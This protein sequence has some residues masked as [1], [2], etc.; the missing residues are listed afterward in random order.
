MF[1]PSYQPRIFALPPGCD[2]S[3]C[4]LQG[5]RGRLRDKP[6]EAMAGVELFV[7][8]HRAARRMKS[9][10]LAGNPGFLPRIRVI[11]DLARDPLI[12]GDIAA[13]VSPLRRRLEFSQTVSALVK[14]IPDLA[15]QTS[16]FDLADSLANLMDEMHGEGVDPA[17]LATLN[18][19]NHAAHWERSL[20]FLN[21]LTDY[22]KGTGRPDREARQRLVI[23]HLAGLWA[24]DP[25]THPVIVAGSTGS[26]GA[27]ALFMKA[28]ANL[29]QGAVVLP[30]FDF[31][32]PKEVQA[33]IEGESGTGDHPQSGLIKL[34]RTLG[35][36][37]ANVQN[38]A[39]AEPFNPA[40][41][42]LVSLALRPAPVTDQWL[43][44]GPKLQDLEGATKAISLLEA[45][46]PR[47]EAV[48]IA[49]RLRAALE[50]GRKATLISPNR[51]LT[52][53]VAAALQ[54]W[55]IRPDDSAGRPLPLSP[56]GV[57]LRLVA[58]LFN[59]Q[60]TSENLLIL[61]KHPLTHSAGP[62]RNQHL[63]RSR[64]L[65]LDILRGGAPFPDFLQI[66]EWASKR[67]N[68]AEA[69]GWA[70]WLSACFANLQGEFQP[71]TRHVRHHRQLAEA[72]ANGPS[73]AD[74][75]SGL[76]LEP[77]GIEAL[78]VFRDLEEH[79]DAGGEMSPS[80]YVALLQSVLNTGEVRESLAVHPDITIWGTL[81]A[82]MQSADLVILGGL[83][84]G[85][86]PK[87]PDPDPWL[88][89]AMRAEAGLLL[90]ERRIGLSAH[91]FQQAIAAKT[92]MLTRSVRDSD[93]PTVASRWLN[94]L[95]NL[96]TGL[97]EPGQSALR[98]MVERGRH[99]LDL[100]KVLEKPETTLQPE[101]RPSPCPP[102]SAR[103]KQLSVTQIKTL[104]R[105]PYAIYA[106][107]VLKLR[108]LDPIRREPDALLRG[109]ALH[110][111]LEEFVRHT[112]ENIPEDAV[113]Q[114]LAT[115][116]TIFAS[117]APWP[118]T[119]RLWMARLERISDWFV[120]GE[121]NRRTFASPLAFER[122][123]KIIL[124]E[125]AFT[126]TGKADRIDQAQDG[127]L[128]IYDYKS[129]SLPSKGQ[130][131]HFD[132]QLPLEGAMAERGGFAELEPRSVS[133]LEY[134]GL[135]SGGKTLS[136]TL[137]D[138]LINETWEGLRRLIRAFEWQNTGYTARA[139]MEKRQDKS[140]YDHL[141]RLG[142]WDDSDTAKQEDV[143]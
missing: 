75:A 56:P 85:I 126:L 51:Q 18:V 9:L 57:F 6:V 140:D 136:V 11:T 32:L 60:L 4:L 73:P 7:N 31:D 138:D 23:E 50:E 2:F 79:A 64:E 76:W 141:S 38:W 21:L 102:P 94:R 42:A 25:P 47:A 62:S 22:F 96:L 20:T 88:S 69:P 103:P 92:V 106:R 112:G 29:P 24:V 109:Q 121:Q 66:K 43:L 55:N 70:E 61:L 100:A 12:T 131:E 72:L 52:R 68:D 80:D 137:S 107:N 39:S 3:T 122:S 89:R 105:D 30:G 46:N 14:A 19:G 120:E 142:E 139:R 135:G 65:E 117:E 26:R 111:V 113:A 10:F 27:T 13:A 53:Q 86:W 5:L 49:L 101:P 71:L 34:L 44:E 63:L 35:F 82:R 118:A 104:I 119:R 114:L 124:E 15:S 90:P 16:V 115:A 84:E 59:Q 134:I 91:D 99:W 98:G 83:N 48:A 36:D 129:G 33:S 1:D 143:A 37:A 17:I 67:G 45:P 108:K 87:L 116:E 74:E 110:S 41:N 28:V 133:G 81:E 123:G 40:R 77:A 8:T 132:K 130:I 95:T 127:S 97:G 58:E 78:R 128:I 93:A 125:P 54:R